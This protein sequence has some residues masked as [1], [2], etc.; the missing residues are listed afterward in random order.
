MKNKIIAS[1][2][3]IAFALP[4]I[5]AMAQPSDTSVQYAK[6]VAASCPGRWDD[7]ACLKSVSET[8]MT[9][10]SLYGQTLQEQKQNSAANTLKEH[11]AAA[12]AAMEGTYPAPAM[13]SA[14]TECANKISDIAEETQIVPDQSLYQLL[15][16]AVLCLDKDRRCA[17]IEDGL[18]AY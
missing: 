18:K 13:R 6:N 2:F 11:C 12:T 4:A 14:Y 3:I 15:V 17:A 10:T 1:I 16:S 8:T 5:P 7:Q 9:M